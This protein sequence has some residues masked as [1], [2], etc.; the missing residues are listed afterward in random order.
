MITKEN[1]HT[2]AFDSMTVN[3]VPALFTCL[4]IDREA[5]PEGM[6]AYDIRE[7]DDGNSFAA[8]EPKVVVNHAG[9]ILTRKEFMTGKKG[10]VKIEEY[11][12]EGS[13]T[14]DEW[15]SEQD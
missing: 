6:H 3:G 15:L 9:T 2:E 10:Y 14:L 13:M 7:A 11:D 1:I 5:V 8:V 4:R 12:F